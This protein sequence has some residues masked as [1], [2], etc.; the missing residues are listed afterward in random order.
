MKI[1]SLLH[2]RKVTTVRFYLLGDNY[3]IMAMQNNNIEQAQSRRVVILYALPKYFQ[4][5]PTNVPR[6][7]IVSIATC[8][9]TS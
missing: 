7:Y 3:C 9:T 1:N 6:H 2:Q 5:E 8:N 4:Q